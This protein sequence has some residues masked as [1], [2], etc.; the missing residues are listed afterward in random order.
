[1]K[2]LLLTIFT[3]LSFSACAPR[4]HF[5]RLAAQTQP[6]TVM[7]EVDTI[8]TRMTLEIRDDK[9][10]ITRA[11]VPVTVVGAGVLIS[12]N[13]HILTCAH[14]FTVGP[15]T[16]IRAMR[17]DGSTVPATLLYISTGMDLGLLKIEK[18]PYGYARLAED[19]LEIGQEVLAIGYPMGLPFSVSHGII[20][21]FRRGF[22]EGY[23]FTQDD[24][25]VNPG[26]SGGPLFN[27][28]GDV[29]GITTLKNEG[30]GISFAV[31]P[32]TIRKFLNL[33]RGIK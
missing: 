5:V 17:V 31:S 8:G 32:K 28:S 21:A 7:V 6:K 13:G 20:S 9:F 10:V 12:P 18:T 1:M 24:A 19:R 3:L 11:T 26:N 27:L 16:N 14:L 30:E 15:N 23:D 25:A 33:F 22:D 29:I 2:N 4:E